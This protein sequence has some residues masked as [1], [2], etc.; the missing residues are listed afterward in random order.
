MKRRTPIGIGKIKALEVDNELWDSTVVGFGARRQRSAAVAYVVLYRTP[1]GRQRRYTI[2]RH[3]APWTPDTA[4]DEARRILG[5]VAGGA[6]PAA[7]KSVFQN[8]RYKAFRQ[9]R[10]QANEVRA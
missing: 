4:R 7:I 3:G 5:L 9:I 6:D 2:G 10:E 8:L 1:E